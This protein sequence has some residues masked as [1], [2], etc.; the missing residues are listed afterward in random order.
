MLQIQISVTTSYVIINRS[1][2]N[3]MLLGWESFKTPILD[4]IIINVYVPCMRA[5]HSIVFSH[6]AESV[7]LCDLTQHISLPYAR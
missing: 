4:D 3:E 2:I 7:F 1:G 6:T 5:N